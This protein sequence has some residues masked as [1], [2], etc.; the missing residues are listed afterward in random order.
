[1]ISVA[2]ATSQS[3]EVTPTCTQRALGE[4]RPRATPV[5]PVPASSANLPFPWLPEHLVV[6]LLNHSNWY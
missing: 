3:G 1:M 5:V 2:A 4:E 6:R